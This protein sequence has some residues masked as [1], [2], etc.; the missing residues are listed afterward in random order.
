MTNTHR[1]LRTR[2]RRL[3]TTSLP[4][5]IYH[6]PD[7]RIY[8]SS[9]PHKPCHRLRPSLHRRR[10]RSQLSG[11]PAPAAATDLAETPRS[12]PGTHTAGRRRTA[13]TCK[14]AQTH[15]HHRRTPADRTDQL[16]GH[17]VPARRHRRPGIRTASRQSSDCTIIISS[18]YPPCPCAG[19]GTPHNIFQKSAQSYRRSSNSFYSKQ[20]HH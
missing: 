9:L 7:G 12:Q 15:G 2:T 18:S 8:L 10:R 6:L 16:A 3:R 20:H 19:H 11:L 4:T 5:S 13:R 14:T 17:H 1:L